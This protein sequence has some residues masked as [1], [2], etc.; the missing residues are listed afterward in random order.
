MVRRYTVIK[1][2][3]AIK[4][5]STR[6]V[7]WLD[8]DDAGN[9][10]GQARSSTKARSNS[11]YFE[12][13]RKEPMRGTREP[14]VGEPSVDKLTA[15]LDGQLRRTAV[16]AMER[17]RVAQQPHSSTIRYIQADVLPTN[18]AQGLR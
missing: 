18:H 16:Q 15:R 14:K 7:L 1:T 3:C 13:F 4:G 10:R 17:C 12:R 6:A 9:R 8:L 5:G 2:R 11:P